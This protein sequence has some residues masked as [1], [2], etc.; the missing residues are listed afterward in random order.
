MITT[1]AATIQERRV[2][3][4]G[5]HSYR[6]RCLLRS[7]GHGK[8]RGTRHEGAP[9]E[10]VLVF[11]YGL[12]NVDLPPAHLAARDAGSEVAR[13]ERLRVGRPEH[14]VPLDGG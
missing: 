2:S 5:R 4:C 12:G 8:Y 9:S 3:V 7:M 10:H 6:G 14:V 11:L 13:L 1:I